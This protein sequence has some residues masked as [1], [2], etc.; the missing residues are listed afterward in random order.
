LPTIGGYLYGESGDAVWL[1]LYATSSTTA[2]I[3][4]GEVEISEETGYPWKGE[5]KVTLGGVPQDPFSLCVRIPSWCESP[6][7]RINGKLEPSVSEKGYV[8]LTR[9][10]KKGDVVR[11]SFPMEIRRMVSHPSVRENQGKVAIQRG[12]LVYCL[13]EADHPG[14]VRTV[15]LPDNTILQTRFDPDLLGGVQVIEGQAQRVLFPDADEPLYRE[16]PPSKRQIE[17]V[18]LK[19][20]PYYAWDNREPG[21][22]VVWISGSP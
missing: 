16:A 14:G 3:S 5:V 19:A 8:R 15:R 11:L 1:N 17:P 18:K 21:E 13:E 2:R 10:W 20:I 22:M 9:R 12:P 7:M 6:R 4:A